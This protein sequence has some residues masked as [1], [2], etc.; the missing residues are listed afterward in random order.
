MRIKKQILIFHE[1]HSNRYFLVSS[2][3]D[4]EKACRKIVKERLKESDYWYPDNDQRDIFNVDEKSTK[5]LAEMAVKNK[6]C[7]E[8]ID[9]RN[10]YEYEGYSLEDI[11]SP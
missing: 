4:I 10:D 11:E 8:F 1:K 7:F 5:Q 3:E 6:T 2:K 9:L